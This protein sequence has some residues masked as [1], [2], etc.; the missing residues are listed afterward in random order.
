MIMTQ[1][2]LKA[3]LRQWGDKATAAVRSEMKQLHFR[4]TFKPLH[5][6]ELLHAEKQSVLD[7]IC[8]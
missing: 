3:G 6:N 7:T 2:L 4:D 8:S 5:L 1:L